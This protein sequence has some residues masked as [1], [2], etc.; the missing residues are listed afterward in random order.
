[1][2]KVLIILVSLAVGIAGAVMGES[3]STD[4]RAL[5]EASLDTVWETVNE[6]HYDTTFGGVDWRAIHDRYAGLADAAKDEAELIELMNEMLLE[7]KLSHYAVFRMESK[8]GSGPPILAEA[9]VGLDLRILGNEAVITSL[10]ADYPAARAGLKTG[11]AITNID[12]EPVQKLMDAV[13]A[14]HIPRFGERR[15]ISDMADD[16]V[17]RCFGHAGD[18]VQLS[19]E[20][21]DGVLHDVTL[22]MKAR[23]AGVKIDDNFPPV[24]LDF[25]SVRLTD[26]IGYV[27]FSAVLPPA[28]SLFLDALDRMNDVR[29]LIIDIRGNPGGMHQ[30]GEAIASKLVGEKTLFSVFRYRDSTVEVKIEPNPPVF[31]GPVAILIDV[32]NGS[33]SERFSACMQSIGRATIIG[34]QS[35]GS[36][37]PSDIKLLP[38]GASLMYLVAQSLTPDGT[39]LEGRG[40]IPDVIVSLDKAALLKGVD[41]QLDRAVAHLESR[42]D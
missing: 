30:I 3:D 7:L 33:A 1:M 6:Y 25:R 14:E 35:S 13:A 21:S 23:G 42:L 27:Y 36:V 22:P 28:D 15:L 24:Y 5:G 11:Y 39:V 12:G 4:W 16:L 29:G 17:R 18:T 31:E 2:R 32:M 20:D 10:A 40:V 26:D 9:S 19:Y 41:T 34:E 8:A 37:G 38:N